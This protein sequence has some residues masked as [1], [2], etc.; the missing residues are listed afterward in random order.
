MITEAKNLQWGDAENTFITMEIKIG[1][2]WLPFA[3][4]PQDPERHGRECYEK[5]KSGDYGEIADYVEPE[6]VV[7]EVIDARQIRLGL[8]DLNISTDDVEQAIEGINDSAAKETAKIDWGFSQTFPRSN[9]SV[10]A[11]GAALGL[12]DK[13]MD[14]LWINSS[15]K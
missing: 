4:N 13:D 6:P 2:E 7:P 10:V 3:A 8:M 9:P 14:E 1:D 11:I 5:A 15:S 12:S